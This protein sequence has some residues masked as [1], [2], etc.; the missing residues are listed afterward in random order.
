L[1]RYFEGFDQ[2]KIYLL[3]CTFSLTM[4]Q[5]WWKRSILEYSKGIWLWFFPR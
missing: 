1:S 5:N 3:T 4:F 2:K